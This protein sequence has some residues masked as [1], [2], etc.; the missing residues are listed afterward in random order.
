MRF[1]QQINY[2]L[3]REDKKKIT[4]IQL[5]SFY[6]EIQSLKSSQREC[7]KFIIAFEFLIL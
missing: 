6:N 4:E 2:V 3:Q 5:Y 7:R 1:A